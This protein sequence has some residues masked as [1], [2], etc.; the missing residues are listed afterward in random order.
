MYL[1]CPD[2]WAELARRAML[3]DGLRT[4]LKLTMLRR[5]ARNDLRGVVEPD[6]DHIHTMSS[7]LGPATAPLPVFLANAVA[8][9][10]RDPANLATLSHRLRKA[11]GSTARWDALE[12]TTAEVFE[13]VVRPDPWLR[14]TVLN[15]VLAASGHVP[16]A[17]YAFGR[18]HLQGDCP[19]ARDLL[20]ALVELATCYFYRLSPAPP[21]VWQRGT[22]A[23]RGAYSTVYRCGDLAVK[24]GTNL[25]SRSFALEQEALLLQ[26]LIQSPAGPFAPRLGS[27]DEGRG[28]LFREFVPGPTGHELL[29]STRFQADPRLRSRL[30]TAYEAISTYLTNSEQRLDLHPGNFVWNSA[31]DRWVLVDL[32]PVPQIGSDYYDLVSFEAYLSGTWLRRLE[33]MRAEPI[34]SL[35]WE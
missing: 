27:Y 25:A 16:V 26:T 28:L 22:P 3:Y 14:T 8:G 34:R 19:P 11:I 4:D 10:V 9:L 30:A 23:G 1:G 7:L 21:D 18:W 12:A 20:F 6:P 32:G 35:D 29:M 13:A 31:R 33:R 2:R 5:A 15:A 24:V 17:G